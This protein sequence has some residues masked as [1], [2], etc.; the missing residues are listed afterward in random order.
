MKMFFFWFG[1]VNFVHVAYWM[2]QS[3]M[4][5]YSGTVVVE[6]NKWGR[7]RRLD[8]IIVVI[9]VINLF[10]SI[11]LTMVVLFFS[12]LYFLVTFLY[13]MAYCR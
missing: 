11:L 6:W 2:G 9:T 7:V 1:C 5:G 8:T 10:D 13:W 4:V 3:G 12:L